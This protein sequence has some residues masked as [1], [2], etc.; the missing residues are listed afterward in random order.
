MH[1]FAVCCCMCVSFSFFF[2]FLMIRRPPRSTLFPYTTLF[3]SVVPMWQTD[4][5]CYADGDT[6]RGKLLIANYG[7]NSLE[8]K[9][10]EWKL[11]TEDKQVDSDAISISGKNVIPAGE[12]LLNVGNMAGCVLHV[13]KPTAC[14]LS[15]HISNTEYANS[16]QVWIYPDYQTTA[17][18]IIITHEMTNEIARKL[19]NGAKV[20]WMPLAKDSDEQTRS[21]SA[22]QAMIPSGLVTTDYWNYRMFKTI[23]DN[24]KK[25]VSPGTLGILTDPHHPIF[26][27]FP[28]EYH[29]NWQW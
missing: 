16:Y 24:N 23:C 26:E 2:F 4:R 8:G 21:D 22:A 20:L 15:L 13:E 29:T 11:Q 7:G 19:E 5:F 25:T 6:L 10:L 12:G 28:T 14:I 1:F 17:K 18:D 9:T 3:R 27:T